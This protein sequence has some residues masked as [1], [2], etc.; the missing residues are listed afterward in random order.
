MGYNM[1]MKNTV[2]AIKFLL[3]LKRHFRLSVIELAEINSCLKDKE[4]SERLSLINRKHKPLDNMSG[5]LTMMNMFIVTGN[6]NV[7]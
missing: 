1:L 6:S 2:E 4:C 7:Y 5:I 3:F